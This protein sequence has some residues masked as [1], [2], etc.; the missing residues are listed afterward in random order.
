VGTPTH[1]VVVNDDGTEDA[2]VGVDAASN[3]NEGGQVELLYDYAASLLPSGGWRADGMWRY[4]QLLPLHDGSISYP[5]RVGGTPLTGP[6][7]L[8]DR[9]GLP[10][11]WLKDETR[12]PSL[13]N[14]DRATALVLEQAMKSGTT[15]VTCASTGNVAVSLAVGAA[16]AGMEAINFVAADVDDSKL[17]LMLALG[18]TVIKVHQAYDAAFRLSRAAAREFGWIDRNTGVNPATIEAKKTVAFEIWEQLGREV[19]DV[20]VVP[21]GDGP[22]L[23]GMAKGFRELV[24]CRVADRVPRLIGVQA[25]GCQP[26]KRA[27][28]TGDPVRP[29]TPATIADGIAVGNPVSGGMAVRD[30]VRSRGCFVSVTDEGMLDAMRLLAT[31]AGVLAEPA[32]AAALA[33]LLVAV[34]QGLAGRDERIVTLVTGSSLKTPRYL[35]ATGTAVESDADLESLRRAL[36]EE[37]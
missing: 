36:V 33:G 5:L 9:L 6:R 35:R 27:W 18:A 10:Q 23:N 17:Q 11:L 13:S 15:Q 21:V 16:A 2:V 24:E 19:P 8:R 12:G 32:A 28:E 3:W 20:V 31:H 34:E 25:E 22:T 29:T 26:I 14:K 4:R 7:S 30:V 1:A 37:A